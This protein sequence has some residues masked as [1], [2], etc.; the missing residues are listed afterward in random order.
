MVDLSFHFQGVSWLWPGEKA[1][2]VFISLPQEK[3]AEIQFFN[4]NLHEKK[5]GWGAVRVVATIGHTTWQTSIFPDKKSGCYL[6][7]VRASV[8]KAEGIS[9]GDTVN[10]KLCIT[11]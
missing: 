7:P 5:R 11:I 9:A 3:S 6:L 1:A 2:W 8:R 10:L 4:E